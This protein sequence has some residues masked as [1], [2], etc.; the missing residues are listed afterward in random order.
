MVE[1]T[2]WV[3]E[4]YVT[5]IEGQRICI[6]GYSHHH[7][8]RDLDTEDFT[9]WVVRRVIKGT[10]GRNSFFPPIAGYFGIPD[11]ATFWNRV[12]F[13]NF[14]PDCI[15]ETGQRYDAA[16]PEQTAR[17]KER[18]LRIIRETKPIF[19]K[20]FVF[21]TKGWRDFPL[22]IEEALGK[23]RSPLGIEF[24]KFSWGTYDAGD[25]TVMAFGLRHPQGASG[26]LM[27]SGVRQ[28]LEKPLI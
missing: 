5:G 21:S 7:D 6:V 16:S 20:V 14:L 22:T 3:G 2:P 19:E 26:K 15:G 1:H 27:K 24:P 8:E 10:L 9:R 23:E 28:I 11:N 18:F 4:N 17:G 25:H 13:I 12:M